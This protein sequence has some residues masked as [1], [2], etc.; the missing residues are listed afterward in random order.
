ML[1]KRS[2]RRAFRIGTLA[3]RWSGVGIHSVLTLPFQLWW[4]LLLLN[5]DHR[6]I[7]VVLVVL[8]D[9][10]YKVRWG[11]KLS[12]LELLLDS[13]AFRSH[14]V[15]EMGVLRYGLLDEFVEAEALSP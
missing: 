8:G 13:R 7:L 2:G 9:K 12:L 11:Y 10:L 4:H 15:S 3:F 6:V 1:A 5:K 14:V